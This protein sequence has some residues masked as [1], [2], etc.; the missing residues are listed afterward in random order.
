MSQGF[1]T[2]SSDV[3]IDTPHQQESTCVFFSTVRMFLRAVRRGGNIRVSDFESSKKKFQIFLQYIFSKFFVILLTKFG[4]RGAIVEDVFVFLVQEINI[5]IAEYQNES[6]RDQCI[7]KFVSLSTMDG[8]EITDE[9]ATPSRERAAVTYFFDKL[10]ECGSICC[11][12][13]MYSFGFEIPSLSHL[14]RYTTDEL[15][16]PVGIL[17]KMPDSEPSVVQKTVLSHWLKSIGIEDDRCEILADKI[18]THFG[19]IDPYKLEAIMHP[20][21]FEYIAETL[22]EVGT[23]EYEINLIGQELLRMNIPSKCSDLLGCG[24]PGPSAPTTDGVIS[25]HMMMISKHVKEL[26]NSHGLE[27]RHFRSI[28]GGFQLNRETFNPEQYTSYTVVDAEANI[29]RRSPVYL[30]YLIPSNLRHAHSRTSF[31][32]TSRPRSVE[33]KIFDRPSALFYVENELYN[34]N[35]ADLFDSEGRTLFETLIKELHLGSTNKQHVITKLKGYII[36]KNRQ[37]KELTEINSDAVGPII[38]QL[39][40]FLL[41][42]FDGFLDDLI[43]KGLMAI[44]RVEP[45]RAGPFGHSRPGPFGQ[46]ERKPAT[47]RP[48][49]PSDK[50]PDKFQAV[51]KGGGSRLRKTSKKESKKQSKKSLKKNRRKRKTNKTKGKL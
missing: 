47:K 30:H 19:I 38:V 33:V 32:F 1:G 14:F 12:S 28:P 24:I 15:K 22:R 10:L 36:L 9:P 2:Q 20:D 18:I 4:F 43:Q 39:S 17:T 8:T 27:Q 25:W 13:E 23:T 40:N 44:P 37:L 26:K 45:P 21:F 7:D 3:S 29:R 48:A 49:G 41:R 16:L 42:E 50:A 11:Y 46:I 51:E 35:L 31:T 6:T 34:D 5:M